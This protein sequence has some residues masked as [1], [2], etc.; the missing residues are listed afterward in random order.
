MEQSQQ[1]PPRK[2]N[3]DFATE[4]KNAGTVP[5]LATQSQIDSENPVKPENYKQNTS[6]RKKYAECICQFTCLWCVFIAFILVA[7]G[8]KKIHLSDLVITTLIGSTTL[9]LTSFFL[10]VTQYLFNK[11][12]ST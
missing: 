10:L 2:I 8:L 9:T 6:E 3:V 4:V 11:E 5:D 7:S 1:Q 12:M